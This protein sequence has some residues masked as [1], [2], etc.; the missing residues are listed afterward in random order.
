MRC[1]L[2]VS[3]R[4]LSRPKLTVVLSHLAGVLASRARQASTLWLTTRPVLRVG[5]REVDQM[6][7]IVFE[8]SSCMFRR[9]PRWMYLRRRDRKVVSDRRSDAAGGS[10]DRWGRSRRSSAAKYGPDMHPAG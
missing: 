7:F 2:L 6:D 5:R 9:D 8:V 3:E 1:P 4:M 10:A